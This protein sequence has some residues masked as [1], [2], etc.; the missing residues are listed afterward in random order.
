MTKTKG[1]LMKKRWKQ[2]II[3]LLSI[4]LLAGIWFFVDQAKLDERKAIVAR[5]AD[6]ASL[7]WMEN[8]KTNITLDFNEMMRNTRYQYDEIIFTDEMPGNGMN[9]DIVFF[10][11]QYTGDFVIALNLCIES[12]GLDPADYGLPSP[13]TLEDVLTK[14]IEVKTIFNEF[15]NE[16]FR[17]HWGLQPQN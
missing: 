17:D 3:I 11:S 1:V 13:V 9:D 16:T 4:I 10:P 12:D 8:N 14:R 7:F 15:T 6:Y 2:G 5:E